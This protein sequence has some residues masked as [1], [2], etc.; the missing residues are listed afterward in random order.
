LLTQSAALLLVDYKLWA[1]ALT[2]DS[3]AALPPGEAHRERATLFGSIVNTLNHSYVVDL[4]WRAHLEGRNHPFTSR[5]VILHEDVP[6]LRKAQHS[7]NEWLKGWCLAQSDATLSEAIT[8]RFISGHRA[9]MSCGAIVLHI[10][11]HATYHRGFVS[12]L[13]YQIP[14]KP[15]TTDLCAYPGILTPAPG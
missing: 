12:D 10:V 13:F 3:V 4:I 6:E 8:V 7:C 14:V 1:D 5:R 9:Q 2:F 11:N 15:P